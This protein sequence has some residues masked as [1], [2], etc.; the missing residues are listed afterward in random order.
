MPSFPTLYYA[1]LVIW[2]PLLWAGLRLYGWKRKVLLVAAA[3]GMAATANEV[4]QMLGTPNA[5][6][7]DVLLFSVLLTGLYAVA[8][9]VLY[10]ARR[11]RAAVLLGA[12]VVLIGGMMSYHWMMAG[13]EARRLTATFDARNA[14]LFHAKFRDPATYARIFGP[15]PPD[16]ITQPSGHWLA[17]GSAPFTRLII[18]GEGRTWLFYHC[19][20]TECAF[21]PTDVGLQRSADAEKGEISWQT[22]LRP[23]IGDSLPVRILREGVDGIVVEARGQAIA[24]AKA[25]PPIDPNPPA[26]TIEFVGSFADAACLGPHAR[27]RQVWLW[28][29]QGRLYA[30]GVFQTLLAGQ[31]AQFV[32]PAV[33][34]EG[35]NAGDASV[36]NW[37]REGRKYSAAIALTGGAVSLTLAEDGRKAEAVTLPRR[38][39]FRDDAIEFA[40]LTTV[41][42]WRHWFETVLVGSFFSAEIPGCK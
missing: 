30:V 40:P 41:A 1:L 31:R 32:T 23:S 28:R 17:Q 21:G 19:G 10:G 38:A 15:F 8:A 35:R 27:V 7:I 33:L 14:L 3:V 39:I 25:P 9:V 26:K 34:G 6:R 18:N 20:E 2:L 16:S 24:F 29:T 13:R 22:I 36:F 37:Q 5:I 12:A 11:R 42:D 4:W